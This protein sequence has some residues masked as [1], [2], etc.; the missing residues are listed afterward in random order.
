MSN[1]IQEIALFNIVKKK[2]YEYLDAKL[3]PYFDGLNRKLYEAAFELFVLQVPIS[4]DTVKNCIN[5]QQWN[6]KIKCMTIAHAHEIFGMNIMTGAVNIPVILENTY[7][8]NVFAKMISAF[9]DPKSTMQMKKDE[10]LK[11]AELIMHSQKTSDM[12]TYRGLLFKM[13][14]Q[15]KSGKESNLIKGLIQLKDEN[16]K[17]IF[18][19]FIYPHY[20]GITAKPGYFKTTLALNLVSHLDDIGKR[21]LWISWEDNKDFAALKILAIKT[22]IDKDILVRQ[23][24]TNSKFD[25]IIKDATKNIIFLD[26]LRDSK[27]LE[28]DVNNICRTMDID[29]IGVDYTQLVMESYQKQT[30]YERLKE[31][32]NTWLRINKK[33]SIPMLAL[34]QV[35]KSAMT[36]NGYLELGDEKGSGDIAHNL[37]L[38]ISLNEPLDNSE[39]EVEG[40]RRIIAYKNKVTFGKIGYR[41]VDFEPKSGRIMFAGVKD[42]D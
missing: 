14:E 8:D 18:G 7:F 22:G 31:F 35:P 24:L 16:L 13:A 20:M 30:E 9:P 39:P 25:Q 28:V 26:E 15:K 10:V 17:M 34:S 3:I 41:Y 42:D 27:H 21:S 29:F 5:H 37:R 38:N 33:N 11:A 1:N 4:E 23:Q 40:Y 2:R 12:E 19:D 6:D 32:S 36:N